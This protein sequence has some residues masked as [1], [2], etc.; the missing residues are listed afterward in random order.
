MTFI[1]LKCLKKK[2]KGLQKV[3]WEVIRKCMGGK[4]HPYITFPVQDHRRQQAEQ[5][6]KYKQN[7]IFAF[8]WWWNS[9]LLDVNWPNRDQTFCS[10]SSGTL[11]FLPFQRSSHLTNLFLIL[12]QQR[13][14]PELVC[15][16]GFGHV[17]ALRRLKRWFWEPWQLYRLA[18]ALAFLA[19]ASWYL[20]IYLE[21]MQIIS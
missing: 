6:T 8:T 10:Y 18:H 7:Q 19:T 16:F 12:H 9:Q 14:E 13:L 17:C 21:E 20:F 4:R 3:I 2:K 5:M 15:Q 11:H 1:T